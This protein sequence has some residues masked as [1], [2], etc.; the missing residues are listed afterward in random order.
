MRNLIAV[1]LFFACAAALWGCQK[2]FSVEVNGSPVPTDSDAIFTL[3]PA[4]TT[5]SDANVSGDFQADAAL[6]AA[7]G[8]TVTVNVTRAGNWRHTT[9]TVNGIYF[10]GAGKLTATGTQTVVMAAAGKPLTAGSTTIPLKLGGANCSVVVTVTTTAGG[11][12]QTA[13]YYYKATIG[14]VDYSLAVTDNNGFEAGSGLGGTDD[15]VFGAGINYINPPLPKGRTE[16]GASFGVMHHYVNA[17]D[18]NV[19]S[20]FKPGS[21]PYVPDNQSA[22]VGA[23]IG[24]TD[25]DGNDWD[26]QAGTKEQ[27]GSSFKILSVTDSYDLLGTYYFKV[28]IQFNCKLY[29]VTTG[30][31]KQVTNGEMVVL[32]GKI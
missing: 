12:V 6:T 13:G 19:K 16:I 7:S 10:T 15:V 18:A 27:T 14:G 9:P 25:P 17:T 21:Y 20:F 22:T 11:G 30:A 32:F 5:C 28:K 3:V 29:N 2:E 23:S 31:V 8:L 24:W 26:T 4:G 1:V